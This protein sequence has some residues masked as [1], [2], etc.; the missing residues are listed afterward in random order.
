MW[1]SPAPSFPTVLHSLLPFPCPVQQTISPSQPLDHDD[2]EQ[3]HPWH[4]A[5]S[6]PSYQQHWGAPLSTAHQHHPCGPRADEQLAASSMHQNLCSRGPLR[7][8]SGNLRRRLHQRAEQ[9]QARSTWRRVGGTADSRR[10]RSAWTVG[11]ARAEQTGAC[12]P[13]HHLARHRHSPPAP[14]A[15]TPH[16]PRRRSQH[17]VPLPQ[18]PRWHRPP[19]RGPPRRRASRTARP[20]PLPCSNA[21]PRRRR[22]CLPRLDDHYRR[23]HEEDAEAKAAGEAERRGRGGRRAVGPTR[24]GRC[25]RSPEAAALRA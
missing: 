21:L 14:V 12:S 18:G 22:C 13:H 25:P 20:P 17:S 8:V 9:E 2:L 24:G 5:S 23:R 10:P 6:E 1:L 19:P 4:M 15:V 16:H 7:T 3:H 11:A